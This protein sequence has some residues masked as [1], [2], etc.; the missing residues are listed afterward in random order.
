MSEP[1]QHGATDGGGGKL[2]FRSFQVSRLPK[3]VSL[4][5]GCD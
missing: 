1:S 3:G 4:E 2:F 5:A